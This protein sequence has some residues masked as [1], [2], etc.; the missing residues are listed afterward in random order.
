MS[1]LH[2]A[3]FPVP[4]SV[5]MCVDED[6]IGSQFYVMRVVP[7]RIFCDCRMPDLSVE[8]RAR[9]FDSVNETLAQLHVLDAD[10]LGLGDFG[11]PGNYFARQTA[12]WSR[13]RMW[14]RT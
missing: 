14:K 7:G 4:E 13:Q 1:A 11:R 2:A 12:R 9:V 3:G 10:K 8:E 6:V 5:A